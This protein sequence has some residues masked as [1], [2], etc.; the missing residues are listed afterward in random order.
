[1]YACVISL[2]VLNFRRGLDRMHLLQ[3]HLDLWTI[4]DVILIVIYTS[5]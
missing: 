2:D 4:S 3:G 5:S 1:M